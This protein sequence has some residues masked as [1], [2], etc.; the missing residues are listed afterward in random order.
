MMNDFEYYVPGLVIIAAN[1]IGFIVGEIDNKNV[2]RVIR[3]NQAYEFIVDKKNCID[4]NTPIDFKD[5]NLT[6]R[7]NYE[8]LENK[9]AKLNQKDYSLQYLTE[10]ETEIIQNKLIEKYAGCELK[11]IKSLVYEDNVWYD[12]EGIYCHSDLF[13]YCNEYVDLIKYKNQNMKGYY[14]VKYANIDNTTIIPV[15]V[16]DDKFYVIE[17]FTPIAY[18][19]IKI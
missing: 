18:K 17:D 14:L 16:N 4:Y 8:K 2:I 5:F 12:I 1:L 9:L 7:N 13:N 11:D 6:I 10:K 19:K 3:N 15:V